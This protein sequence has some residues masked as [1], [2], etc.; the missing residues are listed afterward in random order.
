MSPPLNQR[1]SSARPRSEYFTRIDL[2][3]SWRGDIA[4]ALPEDDG[5]ETGDLDDCQPGLTEVGEEAAEVRGEGK[6]LQL[7]VGE[8]QE[9]LGGQPEHGHGHGGRGDEAREEEEEGSL[10][11]EDGAQVVL[12]VEQVGQ[13]EAGQ[14]EGGRQH[15]QVGQHLHYWREVGRERVEWNEEQNKNKI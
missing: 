11:V 13:V 9:L 10:L 3:K 5:G 1:T 14:G 12:L 4:Q 2:N 6:V 8:H 15:Q 7:Q